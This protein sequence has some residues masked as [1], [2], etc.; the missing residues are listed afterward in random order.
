ML[1][2]E[3][4]SRFR[5]LQRR[6]DAGLITADEQVELANLAGEIESG[7]AKYLVPAAEQI[8]Q[9]RER[10]ECQNRKLEE[11]V[12]RREAFIERLRCFLSDA[13]REREAIDS[14]L[15]AVLAEDSSDSSRK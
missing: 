8:R 5:T 6:Q 2:A 1:D 13:H 10:V 9:N 7:E 11:L 12:R 15:A 4:K 3:K 14:E